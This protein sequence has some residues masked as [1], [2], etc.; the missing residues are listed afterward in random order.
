[1]FQQTGLETLFRQGLGVPRHPR[2][3]ADTGLQQSLGGDL[4]SRENKVAKRDLFESPPLDHPFI[5]PLEPPAQQ[6]DAG[7][8]G[9]FAYFFLGQRRVAAL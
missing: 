9:Q 5:Q 8:G 7:T 6:D 4:P 2:Q 3:K 1:M